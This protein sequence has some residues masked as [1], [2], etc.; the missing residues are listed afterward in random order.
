MAGL[1]FQLKRLAVGALIHCGA[2]FMCP[3]MNALKAAILRVGA[4]VGALLHSALNSLVCFE[5]FHLKTSFSKILLF[6]PENKRRI[7]FCQTQVRLWG[8]FLF[9]FLGPILLLPLLQKENR[10]APLHIFYEY[11]LT[12]L[13]AYRHKTCTTRRIIRFF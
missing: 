7:R 1:L 9:C 2:L 3:N 12:V 4:M 8:L 10:G 11:M 13:G 5:I 6:C